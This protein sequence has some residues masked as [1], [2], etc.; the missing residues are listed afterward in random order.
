MTD[1]K[2][3]ECLRKAYELL[4]H[5]TPLKCDCGRLCGSVCC[6][7][8]SRT[9]MS[10]FPYE[11]ELLEGKGDYQIFDSVSNFGSKIVVCGGN[12]DRKSR[13]L[14]CRIYPLFP[15]VAKNDDGFYSV[16]VIFDPRAVTCPLV[17]YKPRLSRDFIT[18]VR[19]AGKYLIQNEEITEYL[20]AVSNELLELE[21]LK[22]LLT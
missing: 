20:T 4:E 9:G 2:A 10:L 7:G 5:A 17:L 6:K 21:E 14:S 15:V 3:D 16:N 19:R 1:R 12:C 18:A 8:D 11:S 22:K 13:P